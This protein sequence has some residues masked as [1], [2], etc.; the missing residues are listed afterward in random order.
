MNHSERFLQKFSNYHASQKTLSD[1]Y[2][3]DIA[4]IVY[5]RFEEYFVKFGYDRYS[6]LDFH[7]QVEKIHA[8][9]GN[10]TNIFHL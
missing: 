9:H 5:N 3:A 2:D 6:Y 4:E 7:G 8:L 1:F 10:Q